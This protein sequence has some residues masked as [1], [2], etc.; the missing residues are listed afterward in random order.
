[1]PTG[2]GADRLL[3]RIA[4][5]DDRGLHFGRPARPAESAAELNSPMRSMLGS[6]ILYPFSL[7][8]RKMHFV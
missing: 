5:R 8:V 2:N 7:S 1:M 6:V 4:L 3:L